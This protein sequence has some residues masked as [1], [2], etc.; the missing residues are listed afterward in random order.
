MVP[1]ATALMAHNAMS[2]I[3]LVHDAAHVICERN[4]TPTMVTIATANTAR[5]NTAEKTWTAS[6]FISSFLRHFGC[7]SGRINR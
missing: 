5:A 4:N 3:A 7:L 6:V 1:V 2:S